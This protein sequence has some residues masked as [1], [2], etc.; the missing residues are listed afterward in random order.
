MSQSPKHLK[1][2]QI[3]VIV[4]TVIA[5]AGGGY[6]LYKRT[7]GTN[8]TPLPASTQL[9]TVQLGNIVNS[10]SA[11][12]AV[13]FYREKLSFNLSGTIDV[14]NVEAGDVVRAGQVLAKLES[15]ST[16]PLQTAITQAKI[17]LQNAQDDLDKAKT[18]YT[19][20]E[21]NQAKLAVATA[22]VAITT[23]QD[24]LDKAKTP[25]TEAD[26]DQ[27]KLAVATALVAIDTAQDNL[28][29]AKTPYTGAD[30]D[31]AKLA[32]TS[33]NL[34]LK[35]AQD[36]YDKAWTK[37]TNDSNN[38]TARLNFD[39]KLAQLAVAKNDMAQAEQ[40]L[41]DKVA[42][43]D[44]LIVA[45][46]QAQLVL[47]R[48]NLAQAEQDLADKVAGADPLIV[49][50][51]QA[52]LVLARSNLTKAEQDLADM[53]ADKLAIELRQLKVTG[54]QE[55]LDDAVEAMNDAKNI[56]LTAPFDGVVSSVSLDAGQKATAKAAV[57]E[58]VKTSG[59]QVNAVVNEIDFARVKIGQSVT[60]SVDALSNA[61]ITGN[62]STLSLLG[63]A[64]S[65]VVS[66]PLTINV[67]AP[68][69]VQLGEGMSTTA[70]ILVQQVSNVLVIP[71]RAI[72]GTTANPTVSVMVNGVLQTRAVTLGLSDDTRT[73]VIAGL[74]EGDS[75]LVASTT[76]RTS[77]NGQG[78]PTGGAPVPG[79]GQIFR[80]GG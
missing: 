15:T 76:S 5:M 60:L 61:V 49:A 8:N 48:S 35:T 75:V 18:P 30:I 25:Y 74:Q 12:G 47:A 52:Q 70:T 1:G 7:T 50:Q 24:N 46:R 41:A 54:A 36:D 22:R 44:P 32:V 40:D 73:Q 37:Y 79:G 39:Q 59:A 63:K 53:Q 34:T 58:L 57:I 26:I 56:N 6:A 16:V 77:T 80:G 42:G 62:V 17:N 23:A 13:A 21:I 43:A 31:K 4:V 78:I 38:V 67:T 19:D 14:M 3:I 45:Q 69:G 9:A 65:G 28:D 64:N 29:K 20:A 11:S 68:R 2:W 10:V 71:N 33:A 27:A 51:R 55:A 66:Y 72:G